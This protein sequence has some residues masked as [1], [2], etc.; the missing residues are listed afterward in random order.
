MERQTPAAQGDRG[1]EKLGGQFH[2]LD[3]LTTYRA[4][5]IAARYAIPIQSAAIIAAFAFHGGNAHG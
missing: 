5:H 1:M 3:T 2:D 4:Q